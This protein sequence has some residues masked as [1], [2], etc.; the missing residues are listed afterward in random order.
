M[1]N[2]TSSRDLAG[3]GGWGA[4]GKGIDDDEPIV[5]LGGVQVFG[6]DLA[7]ADGTGGFDAGGVPEGDLEAGFGGEGG[8][9]D[10]DGV[11]LD[12]EAQPRVD[13]GDGLLMGQRL[14]ASGASGLDIKLRQN[15]DGERQV[16]P[17]E[18]L[19]RDLRFDLLVAAR[20]SGVEHDI[21][22]NEG[23]RG[24]AGRRERGFR[25]R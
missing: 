24:R 15:L 11:F 10:G 2:W 16:I 19:P 7:A 14:G 21:G 18:N 8:L 5:V 22:V 1:G 6:E 25:Q 9:E 3:M 23:H 13:Q 20:A 4:G 17:A 12:G